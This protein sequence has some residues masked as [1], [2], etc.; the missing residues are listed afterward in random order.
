MALQHYTFQLE[1]VHQHFLYILYNYRDK[2]CQTN[3]TFTQFLLLFQG[4][5]RITKILIDNGANVHIRDNDGNTPLEIAAV[6][7][8]FLA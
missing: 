5:E 3:D 2:V 1:L 8:N 7:G 6:N 4:L